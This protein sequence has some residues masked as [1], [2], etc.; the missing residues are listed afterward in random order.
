MKLLGLD[1]E[2]SISKDIHGSDP[3]DPSNDIYTAIAGDRPDN[4][5]V[6][7]FPTGCNRITGIDY[8]KYDL[9][10]VH[11]A[12]F[13]IAYIWN[14]PKFQEFLQTGGRIWCTAQAEY[15]LSAQRHKYPS[16]AELQLK[17][18]KEKTKES[19]ISRLFKAGI[20][21]DKIIA[22][23]Q[24]HKRVWAL[25]NKYAKDDVVSMLRVFSLQYRAVKAAGMMNIITMHQKAL[26]AVIM[27]HT[28]GMK[29][30]LI[31][32]ENTLRDFK[33]KSIKYL[34]EATDLVGH[35][36]DER[37]GEFN[38]N[39][40]KHKSA[41]LFGGNFK[42]KVRQEAGLYK[43]G[44]V[45]Y[46]TVEEDL[47]IHGFRL[48]LNLTSES[49]ID[50]RFST[51]NKVLNDITNK[52]DN[53]LAR[54]YCLLQKQAMLYGKM[55]STYLEPFL[56]FNV[57][58][59]LYP[60]F[61]TTQ[62]IS[63]RLSS[64]TPNFQ[65][66]CSSDTEVLT[67]R[68]WV[69][70]PELL[71]SDEVYQVDTD[72][73]VGQFVKPSQIINKKYTGDIISVAS[74]WGVFMYTPD[75]RIIS[76]TRDGNKKVE[77]AKEW[78]GWNK[79][80]D[81][82]VLRSSFTNGTRKLTETE[83][84][85][86]ELAIITQAEGCRSPFMKKNPT[87]VIRL[88]GE[89][90]QK[91]LLALGLP[92]HK[93]ANGRIRLNLKHSDIAEWLDDSKEKNFTATVLSLHID[94]LKWFYNTIHKWDGDFTRMCTYAQKPIRRKSLGIV[95]AVAS[96]IGKSTSYYKHPNEDLEV[97]NFHKGAKRFQSRTEVKKTYYEGDVYC[98]TVP[99]GAFLIRRN[100]AVVVTGNCPASGETFEAIQGCIVAPPGWICLS[101]DF[102]QLEPFVTALISGDEKLTQDL[103]NGVCL[104][105]RA[106][107]WIPRLSE[108]KTYDE[109]YQLAVVEK[110][111]DWVLKRKKAKSIN[112]KRAYGG[113]AKSLAEAE[114]LDIDDVKA[115]FA[116]QEEEYH[117]HARFL[118]DIYDNLGN[119][120][121][122][123]RSIDY[124]TSDRRGMKFNNGLELL[125]IFERGSTD[126]Q[127]R[128]DEYR[129]YS[130]Y[131][132]MTGRRYS[133][134]QTGQIDK[135]GRLHK[136]YSTTETRNYFTQGTAAD[137]MQMASCE[138][139]DYCLK[140]KDV[141]LVRQI[142]DEAGFY[143]K[144]DTASIH[145]P[146]ICAIMSSTREHF[147]KYL[148]MDIPFDFRVEAKV[149]TNFANL[150]VY[151]D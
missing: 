26:L 125:P 141:K 72:T 13:D 114:D 46:K 12:S 85:S 5:H 124:A 143:V 36:W 11:N 109:I 16:L 48:P 71:E 111:P 149:G 74:D 60:K 116:G 150:E 101:V 50:G 18:L 133:F 108:G 59:V 75:H 95:Q 69:L 66:C 106:V 70:F 37:L 119:N 135:W 20:G 30:D 83:K 137:V 84:F 68:G 39:S 89:R 86:L 4:V 76:Y 45:K 55:C 80:I 131:T 115:V 130:I 40:P 122:V 132:E 24:T 32:C 117:Q 28:N 92:T 144:K 127:Y 57:N 105:C 29:L 6:K 64:S 42:I 63:G 51:D 82:K 61:N 128:V 17:Y 22:A 56:K 77:H 129:K 140:N 139:F 126:A 120:E 65:N 145:I 142:H 27:M 146:K 25:Y 121:K 43:N 107:S 102:S 2:T 23:K 19:R 33:I 136:R 67:R 44:N 9:L 110:H 138:L 8:T 104:H 49:K 93:E 134:L 54:E 113:G 123:S 151:Y 15:F 118:N 112:F 34:K 100:G 88:R 21:A 81:R 103:L 91:Q 62:T 7:H 73:E 99:S 58:G 41:M 96:M 52:S 97:I 98:V 53:T 38:V 147:K 78:L 87:Y 14:D 10:V 47:Y 79:I 1:I 148:G 94:D 35:M 3:K 31:R 90:K